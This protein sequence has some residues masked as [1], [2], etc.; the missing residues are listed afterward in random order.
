MAEQV[1]PAMQGRRV[2]DAMNDKQQLRPVGTA[3][4][5][6]GHAGPRSINR[7]PRCGARNVMP[8]IKDVT[9]RVEPPVQTEH[10]ID[11]AVSLRF[12][13]V[14]EVLHT[15][16]LVG[17]TGSIVNDL[18]A[19]GRLKMPRAAGGF[20][21][22]DPIIL[23]THGPTVF[24]VASRSGVRNEIGSFCS[25]LSLA[26]ARTHVAIADARQA[27][28]SNEAI[29]ECTNLWRCAAGAG[30]EMIQSLDDRTRTASGEINEEN[31]NKLVELLGRVRDGASPCLNH[32][33]PG[34]PSWA[35]QRQFRRIA[36]NMEARLVVN[37][38]EHNLLV[39]DVSQGGMRIVT[40]QP[41][42]IGAI[43]IVRMRTGRRFVSVVA[44]HN[45]QSVGVQFNRELPPDDPLLAGG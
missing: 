19:T 45:G 3:S 23:R 43:V 27:M 16:V 12:A 6:L 10:K 40:A 8:I 26:K 17:V 22:P 1:R 33:T 24:N 20:V 44:W 13:V 39:A 35:Q 28:T 15:G 9:P 25:I 31:V 41:I 42:K 5:R 29:P 2:V 14:Q 21:P 32:G 37:G 18:F 38:G 36:L 4:V 34:V 11:E 30:V 7:E